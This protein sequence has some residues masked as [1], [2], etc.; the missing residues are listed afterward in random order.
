MALEFSIS[1]SIPRGEQICDQHGGEIW[2]TRMGVIKGDFLTLNSK[3]KVV[4]WY[5]SGGNEVKRVYSITKIPTM[6]IFCYLN[7]SVDLMCDPSPSQKI[8]RQLAVAIL[9]NEDIMHI[10]M[11][12]GE[13]FDIILP[14]VMEKILSTPFGLILQ[15]QDSSMTAVEE[16]LEAVAD[17]LG[18]DD[19]QSSGFEFLQSGYNNNSTSNILSPSPSRDATGVLSLSG[20][21]PGFGFEGDSKPVI[22]G[23]INGKKLK[24]SQIGQSATSMGG[25]QLFSLTSPY[26]P[27]RMISSSDLDDN[28]TIVGG[29]GSSGHSGFRGS[30]FTGQLLAC[31]DSLIVVYLP[32]K[33]EVAVSAITLSNDRYRLLATEEDRRRSVENSMNQ[34][35]FLEKSGYSDQSNRSNRSNRSGNSNQ[36]LSNTS[37]K[38]QQSGGSGSHQSQRMSVNSAFSSSKSIK[39]PFGQTQRE[40]SRSTSPR[41]NSAAPSP[42]PLIDPANTT[43]VRDSDYLQSMILGPK[44][45]SFFG[46]N[47]MT[48]GVIGGTNLPAGALSMNR[49]TSPMMHMPFHGPASINSNTNFKAI[50]DHSVSAL[51]CN[52]DLD[53]TSDE[54]KLNTFHNEN[55]FQYEPELHIVSKSAVKLEDMATVTTSSSASAGELSLNEIESMFQSVQTLCCRVSGALTDLVGNYTNFVM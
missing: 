44:Q 36:N 52:L 50:Q 11:Y 22:P 26:A 14:S 55:F 10:Y 18:G 37:N 19:D 47:H 53:F 31:Y 3:E 40:R 29:G 21:S 7:V 2:L 38:S 8:D 13:H 1:S 27:I 51:S 48:G 42:F 15:S 24:N 30:F 6:A 28:G 9:T 45:S 25:C 20:M 33:K 39:K 17:I 35:S 49:T 43:A 16:E 41:I 5:G 46:R 23:T 32:L 34:S 12:T 54:L 4:K